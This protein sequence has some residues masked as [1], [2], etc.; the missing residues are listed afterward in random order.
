MSLSDFKSR[1]FDLEA[2]PLRA[3]DRLDRLLLIMALAM[4]GC[5]RAGQEDARD[6][7]TPLEKTPT[8]DRS[9]SLDLSK[10]R[11]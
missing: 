3:P 11:P 1:G 8:T 10:T 6:H 9:G 2:T 4:H 5:V 7:P